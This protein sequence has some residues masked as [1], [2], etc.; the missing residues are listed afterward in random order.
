M[1][2]DA[3]TCRLS[4]KSNY[5]KMLSVTFLVNHSSGCVW[6]K[7][8]DFQAQ[9]YYCFVPGVKSV[10]ALNYCLYLL[11]ERGNKSAPERSRHSDLCGWPVPYVFIEVSFSRAQIQGEYYS[12][13]SLRSDSPRSE[14]FN[15]EKKVLNFA[16]DK[17][18]R[19][20]VRKT[21]PCLAE[22]KTVKEEILHSCIFAWK[23]MLY[24]STHPSINSSIIYTLLFLC[25]V[26]GR[27][28]KQNVEMHEENVINFNSTWICIDWRKSKMNRDL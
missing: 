21:R 5:G 20:A 11:S 27:F 28:Y 16:L 8:E 4:L 1:T 10:L 26:T 24:P 2:I 22:E 13:E 15:T 3:I 19:V 14:L 12:N 7:R 6:G 25:R 18:V 17:G 23:K 9:I